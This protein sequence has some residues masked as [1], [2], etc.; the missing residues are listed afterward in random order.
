MDRCSP[1]TVPR[2][3]AV[4]VFPDRKNP[5]AAPLM[6][7]STSS[8]ACRASLQYVRRRTDRTACPPAAVSSDAERE[9]R[10]SNRYAGHTI[11]PLRRTATNDAPLS[12]PDFS[13]FPLYLISA[14]LLEYQIN[15]IVGFAD[16]GI[17]VVRCLDT[18]DRFGG[19]DVR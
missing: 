4:T 13:G 3:S 10:S 7:A 19:D 15:Y 5:S 9:H 6:V 11:S 8:S 16:A 1:M 14:M 18:V 17:L 2:S 12:R